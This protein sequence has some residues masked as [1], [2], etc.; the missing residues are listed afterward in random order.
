MKTCNEVID[1][2][3]DKKPVFIEKYKVKELGLFGSYS[4]KE[5][6]E[7]SDIDIL[8]EFDKPIGLFKFMEFEEDLESLL[9]NKVDLVSKNALKKIIK[10][11][12]LDEVINV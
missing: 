11:R 8:V 6:T 12:I 2:L 9:N 1:I 5:Q 7:N 3:R 4:K 10:Q